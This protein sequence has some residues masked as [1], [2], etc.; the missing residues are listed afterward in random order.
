MGL[1]PLSRPNCERR[2]TT[3]LQAPSLDAATD[4]PRPRI[5]GERRLLTGNPRD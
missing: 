2:G 5:E 4:R 3:L 1:V